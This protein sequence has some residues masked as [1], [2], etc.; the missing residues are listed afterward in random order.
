MPLEM[1]LNELSLQPLATSISEARGRMSRMTEV[2]KK[3]ITIGARPQ[4]RIHDHPYAVFLAESY[5]AAAWLIDKE[6]G[7]EREW[8]SRLRSLFTKYPCLNGRPE[9]I[10]RSNE[11]SATYRGQSA[12]GLLAAHLLPAVAVS[13]LSDPEWNKPELT[14]DLLELRKSNEAEELIEWSDS[15]THASEPVHIQQ[16]E[17]WITTQLKLTPASWKQLWEER[18]ELYPSLDFCPVVASQLGAL[19]PG[20]DMLK[21]I[22]NKLIRLAISAVKWQVSSGKWTADD[23]GGASPE[24]AATLAMFPGSRTFRCAEGRS[25]DFSWHMKMADGIR[26]YFDPDHERKT[27]YVGYIGKH[28]PTVNFK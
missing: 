27:L 26:I 19:S 3:A 22:H 5:S 17:H 23:V 16:H 12:E 25:I 8:L 18:Q 11:M 9:L 7:I 21:Q 20:G 6:N 2:I 4:L 13:F 10:Q 1:V 24:S 28:L 14:I 15:V